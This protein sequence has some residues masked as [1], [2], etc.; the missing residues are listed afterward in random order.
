MEIDGLQKGLQENYSSR[1]Q[2]NLPLYTRYYR[3]ALF[4]AK[5]Q[6]H[7]TFQNTSATKH[8]Q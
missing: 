5:F 4:Q 8:K 7:F 6:S 2:I 3:L 1:P